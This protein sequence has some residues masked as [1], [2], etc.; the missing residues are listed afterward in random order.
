MRLLMLLT[1]LSLSYIYAEFNIAYIPPKCDSNKPKATK[2]KIK[3]KTDTAVAYNEYVPAKKREKVVAYNEYVP[4]NQNSS[5]PEITPLS[6]LKTT[7]QFYREFKGGQELLKKAA[8]YLVFPDVYDAGFI[9]G[10]KYGYGA[11]VQNNSI[12]SY[13]KI[14]STSVGL[15]AGVQRYSLVVVFLTKESLKRFINKE[16][17]KVSLNSEL[18][19]TSWKKGVDINT[20]ALTKDTIVIPFNDI[21]L[22]ANISF[23]GTVFQKLK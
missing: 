7:Q 11:L 6:I 9:V 13:Y 17:W 5:Y 2:K 4:N 10:G 15:K 18:T 1:I 19:F 20:L 22:M 23:E 16:E 12:A 8:A 3:N 14:Y 21:G